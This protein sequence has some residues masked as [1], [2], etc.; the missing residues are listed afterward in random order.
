MSMEVEA[1]YENGVLKLDHPLPIGEN[2]RVRV[3]VHSEL[4]SRARQSQGI[5]PWT[6]DAELLEKF[7]EDPELEPGER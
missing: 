3:T 1:T 5:I 2:Q 4:I 7:A 6:G